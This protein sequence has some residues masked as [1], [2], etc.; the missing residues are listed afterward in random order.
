[1]AG[2]SVRRR[3]GIDG[4]IEVWLAELAGRPAVMVRSCSDRRRGALGR[5]D[6]EQLAEAANLARRQRM[7]L[8]LIL[9]SSGADVSEGVDALHGWGMAALAI[10]ACSGVVPVLAA[11]TGPVLSGPALLLGLCD[12][13]VMTSEAFAYV[14]G[15]AMVAQF[16][17]VTLSPATLGGTGMHARSSG[18]CALVTEDPLKALAEVFSYL[19]SH[20][21]CPPPSTMSD[22]PWDRLVPGL[23]DLVPLRSTASYDVRDVITAVADHGDLLELWANWA[24]QLVTGLSRI[25]GNPVGVIANQPQSLAGTLDIAASQKGA[26]FVRFC[27]AF[28]LPIVTFVDTPGF[29]PGKDLEW[30]GM[31]RHGAELVFAYAQATVPR[32]AVVLRKAMGGAYIAMDSKGLGNTLCFAWP[33]AQTAVMGAREAAQILYRSAPPEDRPRLE[34]EYSE[35]FLSPWGAAERGYIDM[36]IDP[37]ETRRELA[38]AL[39]QVWSRREHLVGRKHDNGPL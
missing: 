25:A 36:V 20:T 32:L 17:G 26:R 15:P 38:R 28:N 33:G 3:S 11:A 13:V 35:R 8:V 24:P 31:I 30:R 18:L 14:S 9:S 19:P 21:D 27:D 6:G 23:R 10:S 39:F 29:L 5:L 34:A 4:S 37:A 12:V 16:T 22:D 2:S 1:M 7:P